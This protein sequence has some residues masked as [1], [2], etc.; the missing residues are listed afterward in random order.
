MKGIIVKTKDSCVI[1]YETGTVPLKVTLPIH[2]DDIAQ[3]ESGQLVE[4]IIVDEFTH[5]QLFYNIG[6]G[7]GVTCAKIIGEVVG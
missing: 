5:P 7:D 2:Q 3:V 1:E 4:F 6:W